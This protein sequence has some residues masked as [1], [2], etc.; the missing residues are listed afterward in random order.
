MSAH[1]LITGINGFVGKHLARELSKRGCK[2][3]GT[4]RETKLDASLNIAVESYTA[5]DLLSSEDVSKIPL[6]GIDAVISLAGFAKVGDS[7]INPEMYIHVNVGVLSVIGERLVKIGSKARV[8]A[9][10]TGAV[11]DSSQPLPL[12]EDS[13]VISSG[14]PYALSKI[15]ME[16]SAGELRA[17][18]LDCIIV[19]PFNHIGPGQEPGFLLPDLYERSRESLTS[20]TH[21]LRVGDLSTKRDYTDVRDVVRAYADLATAEHLD[22]AVYNVCSG[23]SIEGKLLLEHLL[24]ETGLSGKINVVQDPAM[25]RPNDPR[26]VYGNCN[27]LHSQTGW[28]PSIELERTIK[29]FVSAKQ[30]N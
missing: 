28:Q 22:H 26:D 8:I 6:K 11:Y 15:A 3:S 5:C 20:P 13:T 16:K 9:V 18:G 4:S 25:M 24:K 12:S 14:S 1:I 7:F 19:R 17:K 27:R 2:V 23:A 21:D 10:S 30:A 29:D